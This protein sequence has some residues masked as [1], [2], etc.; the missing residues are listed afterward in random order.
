MSEEQEREEG[1]R[2]IDCLRLHGFV[3]CDI[4]AC[5]CGS[6]H[7]RY[8][9]PERMQEIK[10][11]LADAGF[12][13]CNE[14]GNLVTNALRQ[15]LT[16]APGA[17]EAGVEPT[18]AEVL[19][20]AASLATLEDPRTSDW[21]YDDPHDLAKAIRKGP[22]DWR[23]LLT[24][25]TAAMRDGLL[26]LSHLLDDAA[27]GIDENCAYEFATQI[28][29]LLG[30]DGDTHPAPHAVGSALTDL[31]IEWSERAG[32]DWRDFTEWTAENCFKQCADEL[33]A[34]LAAAPA[35]AEKTCGNCSQCTRHRGGNVCQLHSHAT[36][37]D[38]YCND[39]TAATPSQDLT[40]GGSG[41]ARLPH[42]VKVGH[43]TFRKGVT[44]ST[45]VDAARR[46]HR[47]AYPEGYDLS[48]EQK[49][50]NLR[51]LQSA[52]APSVPAAG[53]TDRMEKHTVRE[54]IP[55]AAPGILMVQ[56]ADV[57]PFVH[58]QYGPGMLFTEDCIMT[59]PT[60]Q[61][62]SLEQIEA[63][64]ARIKD[65]HA[66][67]RAELA[68]SAEPAK[69]ARCGN[70]RWV[71]EG[72][73]ETG[74]NMVPCELCWHAN[75][76]SEPQ[77]YME[78]CPSGARC[79]HGC[80]AAEGC[81]HDEPAPATPA[82]AVQAEPDDLLEA[83]KAALKA[84]E[85]VDGMELPEGWNVCIEKDIRDLREAIDAHPQPAAP[86]TADDAV[87]DEAILEV[88]KKH[89]M[90]YA[91]E[92]KGIFMSFSRDILA[93]RSCSAQPAEGGA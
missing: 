89:F 29:V 17:G 1:Q 31:V 68:E 87:S 16:S 73:P 80:L 26:A 77:R 53:D 13:L 79:L 40:P 64:T 7:P 76:A 50:E 69:C 71:E 41:E 82:V 37:L 92:A 47:A 61:H 74:G 66:Q 5:N 35:P 20:W 88:A 75:P 60:R 48:D 23:D 27:Q 19:D 3:R 12:P 70:H 86:A 36:G 11:M 39:W 91:Y 15:A 81:H 44:L 62:E 51:R 9:L 67:L 90:N 78:K 14:N 54:S 18:I 43:T 6:W 4:S 30:L 85:A 22:D 32:E 33:R 45:F 46:W 93:L 34:A 52:A 42:D 83:A 59:Q 72:D 28:R 63:H 49:A 38:C 65:A 25:K 10:D 8:G 56:E 57:E 84:M 24:A 58:P 21:R 55:C 2:A